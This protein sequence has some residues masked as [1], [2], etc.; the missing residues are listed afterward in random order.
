M[1]ESRAIP[2]VRSGRLIAAPTTGKAAGAPVG[3][4]ISRPNRPPIPAA[5][6]SNAVG[7]HAPMPPG[8][9]C[10]ARRPGGPAGAVRAADSRPYNGKR[11]RVHP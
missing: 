3:A 10:H 5:P 11:Q 4:A 9:G 8:A 7:R 6:P 2:A 1:T